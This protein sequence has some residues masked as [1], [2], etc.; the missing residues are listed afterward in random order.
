M[1]LKPL[2]LVEPENTGLEESPEI[3]TSGTSIPDRV[4]TVL[5]AYHYSKRTEEAYIKWIK[6]YLNF[7]KN[8]NPNN[9]GSSEISRYI[10]YLAVRRNV[11][12]S[13]QN[14][15]LCSIIFLYKKVLNKEIND[16][17]LIRARKPK[18]L[19]VVFT[20][21]EVKVIL[22]QLKGVNWIMANLLYGAGLRLMECVRL[23]VKDIEFEYNQ[24]IVRD[25]KGK[26][27]RV[28]IL[29]G[30][31]K[32]KLEEHIARVEKLH[33][34]DL[35]NGFGSV[36][37]PYALDKKY[38]NAGKEPGWQYLFPSPKISFDDR[39]GK[40]RRH[41]ID[42]NVLQR[43]VKTAIKNAGIKK[44]GSCHTFRHSFATHLLEDGYDIRTVQELLGH[45]NVNTTMIYTHVMK[46]GG[47]GVKS[48]ADNL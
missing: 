7:Y 45:E 33:K 21:R 38:P 3:Q 11:S 40:K 15:A 36:Y 5:R 37:L 35:Q 14:L 4:K 27:D 13:T 28:T 31:L 41:H 46:K 17:D 47:F 34:K 16:I 1:K 43:V 39:T 30:I 24:V 25:G 8:K 29:P 9:L 22:E 20:R 23:R 42:E 18:K 2:P 19:P 10:N 32:E 12:A 44:T 6:E 48:P 26:K